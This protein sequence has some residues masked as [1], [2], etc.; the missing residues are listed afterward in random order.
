MIYN[1]EDNLENAKTYEQK[2]FHDDLLAAYN[3]KKTKQDG[4][5]LNK[6]DELILSGCEEIGCNLEALDCVRIELEKGNEIKVVRVK[7]DV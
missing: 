6:I 5:S 2:M 7:R 4:I 3:V 1:L